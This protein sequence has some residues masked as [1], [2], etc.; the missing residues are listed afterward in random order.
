[1]GFLAV[2]LFFSFSSTH[3]IFCLLCGGK[4][5]NIVRMIFRGYF[6]SPAKGITLSKQELTAGRFFR[7]WEKW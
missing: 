1:M 3:V 5:N 2:F 6:S 7:L 4:V